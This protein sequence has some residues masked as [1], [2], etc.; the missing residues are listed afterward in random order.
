MTIQSEDGYVRVICP[1]CG[2]NTHSVPGSCC[3]CGGQLPLAFV[4]PYEARWKYE[5]ELLSV[6][7]EYTALRLMGRYEGKNPEKLTIL[8]HLQY[9]Y[10][11]RYPDFSFKFLSNFNDLEILE[12]DFISIESLDGVESAIALKSLSLT[13]CRRI[14]DAS[15]LA[16]CSKLRVLD[17]ALCNKLTL[18]DPVQDCKQLLYFRYEGK[19]LQS[20]D[21]LKGLRNLRTVILNAKVESQDIEPIVDLSIEKLLVKKRSFSNG[22]IERFQLGNPECKV[23]FV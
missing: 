5:D 14:T 13:E 15:A 9:L 16:K 3:I 8:S 22:E 1:Y 20:I 21:F 10:L 7:K 12:L 4:I 18:L 23:S 11:S 19:Q 2:E 6:L 17:I